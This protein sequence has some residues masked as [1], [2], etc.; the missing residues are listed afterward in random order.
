MKTLAPPL[1]VRNFEAPS[2]S[3][4]G[5]QQHHASSYL[6]VFFFLYLKWDFFWNQKKRGLGGFA[7]S[8]LRW[9]RTGSRNPR[10]IYKKKTLIPKSIWPFL[11]PDYFVLSWEKEKKC[12]WDVTNWRRLGYKK[13]FQVFYLHLN[14]WIVLLRDEAF[15]LTYLM[16]FFFSLINVLDELL[17]ILFF[18]FLASL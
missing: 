15:W 17:F 12:I 18:L 11:S 9:R 1:A 14:C 7:R 6:T 10:I 8:G 3:I 2:P 4:N 13:S 5:R 16:W